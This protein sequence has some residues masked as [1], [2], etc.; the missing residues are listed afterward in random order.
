MEDELRTGLLEQ[1]RRLV[2][3]RQVVLAAAR[4]D[5][6]VPVA[7]EPLDQ[8]R[9]EEARPAR[10]ED[11]RHAWARSGV[12][13]ST[14]PSQLSRFSAYQRMVRATPSSHEIF[15]SQPVSRL[16]FS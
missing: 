4:D 15:G 6:V 5:D 11:S 8:M 1:A 13:Q 12:S 7:L 2:V 16:S 3:P 10:H 9:A 14:R